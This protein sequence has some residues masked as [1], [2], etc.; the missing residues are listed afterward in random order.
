MGKFRQR[1][2][3]S[4]R[5]DALKEL[6][7]QGRGA[8]GQGLQGWG[9]GRNCRA[10][11]EERPELAYSSHSFTAAPAP[12]PA[13]APQTQLGEGF[14]ASLQ[15]S[16]RATGGQCGPCGCG[17]G[18]FAPCTLPDHTLSSWGR[19]GGGQLSQILPPLL[20]PRHKLPAR[21]LCRAGRLSTLP[22]ALGSTYGH[23]INL[24]RAKGRVFSVLLGFMLARLPH[25]PEKI[26]L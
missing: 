13:P 26:S 5:E 10:R 12:A 2:R 14:P 15:F 3:G 4:P 1:R 21:A 22:E 8:A 9:W 24:L 7:G 11:R 16:G 25:T 6:V 18:R 19:A 20:K 17:R 23:T